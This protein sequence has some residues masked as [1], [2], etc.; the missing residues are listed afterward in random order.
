LNGKRGRGGIILNVIK[1]VKDAGPAEVAGKKNPHR[2]RR[3]KTW[4]GEKGGKTKEGI[5]SRKT[6]P[7]FETRKKKHF[8]VGGAK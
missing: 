6:D 3:G 7:G 8:R 2:R 4:D 1:G 5:G